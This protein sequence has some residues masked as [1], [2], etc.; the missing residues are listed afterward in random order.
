MRTREDHKAMMED[1]GRWPMWPQLPLMK[2]KVCGWMLD[3]CKNTVFL[4]NIYAPLMLEG[5][6]TYKSIDAIL[7]D[8]W[9][10]N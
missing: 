6:L 8:G 7:D 9:K 5:E 10:V 4:G 1:P 2:G 3:G